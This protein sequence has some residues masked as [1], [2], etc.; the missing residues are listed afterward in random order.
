[1]TSG[2]VP[3][4]TAQRIS[5]YLLQAE[6]HRDQG[7]TT[8]SSAQLAETLGLT[9]TQ[10]RKDLACFG[11]FGRPGVGYNCDD[12]IRHVRHI[13]GTDH[14]RP[15]LLVGCGNLGRALATYDGFEGRGFHIVALFD[16]DLQKVGKQY[17]GLIVQDIAKLPYVCRRDAV[18]MAVLAVPAHAA[19]DV[20]DQLVRAG[21]QGILSFAP[22]TLTAP[23]EVTISTVALSTELEQ[24]GLAVR[25]RQGAIDTPHDNHDE[26]RGA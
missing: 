4:S 22:L 26:P 16:N 25:L 11:Q 17:G 2:S 6:R 13:L 15:V 24:L 1:M 7:H 19:Q 5:L 20:A 8:L 12:L 21:I 9:A 18:Q 23:P 10:I 3:R 14:V